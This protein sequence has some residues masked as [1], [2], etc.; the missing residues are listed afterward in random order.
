MLAFLAK[1]PGYL[2]V[3]KNWLIAGALLVAGVAAAL[4]IG[5]AKQ[6][7]TD[8]ATVSKVVNHELSRISETSKATTQ[9]VDNLPPTGPDSAN[10][11][12]RE[13]WSDN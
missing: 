5:K 12:L 10:N 6:K 4:F 11:Q 8:N 2:A 9:Q 1:L 3:I 7:A 13:D